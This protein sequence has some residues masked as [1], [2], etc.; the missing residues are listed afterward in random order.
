[1]KRITLIWALLLAATLVSWAVGHGF[2]LRSHAAAS[3]LV[4]AM[5]CVKL[6][7]VALD[8]MELRNAPRA[9]RFAAEGWVAAL[10]G[11]LVILYFV[12]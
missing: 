2:G 9:M 7:Y 5:A 11:L 10:G 12:A 8:F 4:I 3:V 6:R 1:M